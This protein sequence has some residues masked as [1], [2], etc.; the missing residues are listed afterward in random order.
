M[1]SFNL[2]TVRGAWSEKQRAER[3]AWRAARLM[4]DGAY[5]TPSES[6]PYSWCKE[7]WSDFIIVENEGRGKG[8]FQKIPF[9]VGADQVVTFGTPKAVKQ[10][11][12]ALSAGGAELLWQ[13]S[14]VDSL[15]A[16]SAKGKKP[17]F[18][19]KT[20]EKAQETEGGST[21]AAP[22]EEG[23]KREASVP[24]KPAADT[25]SKGAEAGAEDSLEDLDAWLKANAGQKETPAYKAKSAKAAGLRAKKTKVALSGQEDEDSAIVRLTRKM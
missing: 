14:A 7:V 23:G 17:D 11:Y 18:F 8:T 24:G 4:E 15:I 1:T 16:L 2:E 20:E 13:E 25:A 9:T 3:A 21:S 6:Y 5:A 10:E 22:A 12:V 19:K